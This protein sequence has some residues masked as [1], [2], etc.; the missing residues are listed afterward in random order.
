[1]TLRILAVILGTVAGLA[2]LAMLVFFWG[3]LTAA[4]PAGAPDLA[5]Q[6]SVLANRA[7]WTIAASISAY[8]A[9]A[10]SATLAGGIAETILTGRRIAALC[11]DPALAGRPNAADWRAIFSRTAIGIAASPILD[12]AATAIPRERRPAAIDSIR[13]LDLDL[14]WL[15]RL[16]FRREM[17]PLPVLVLAADA[18]LA[19]FGDLAGT[20]WELALAAGFAGW[21][22]ISVVQY[23]ASIALSPFIARTVAAAVAAIRPAAGAPAFGTAAPRGFGPAAVLQP[24][25]V[26]PVAVQPVAGQPVAGQ[27]L[28]GQAPAG[29]RV[30]GH[31]LAGEPGAAPESEAIARNVAEMLAEPLER[32]ADAAERLGAA[33]SPS[34]GRPTDPSLTVDTALAEVR[35][36]IE[37]L[38]A[39]APKR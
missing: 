34:S 26:Q 17:R 14:L 2:A 33:W 22:M 38:L 27:P 28:A 30:L 23:A 29:T 6:L 15:D 37:R 35:A 25:I 31:K 1:M 8:V 18:T 20:G 4:L 10:L 11:N 12:A 32:L 5:A 19:L 24:S 16:T 7:A 3:G 36:G 9:V 21:L 39:A 13:L